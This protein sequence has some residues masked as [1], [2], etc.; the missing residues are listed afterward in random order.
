[1]ASF[2]SQLYNRDVALE[3]EVTLIRFSEIR[4]G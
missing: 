4:N 1:M 3:D 2:L